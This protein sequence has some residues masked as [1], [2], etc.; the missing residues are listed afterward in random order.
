[1]WGR[2]GPL[3]LGCMNGGGWR[4]ISDIQVIDGLMKGKGLK[5]NSVL[6]PL[7]DRIHNSSESS[8]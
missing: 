8:L 5:P 7:Q 2:W 6:C 4:G 3:A 1:M